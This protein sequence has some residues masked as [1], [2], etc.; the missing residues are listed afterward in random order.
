M[1]HPHFQQR[2]E[3]TIQQHSYAIK[4]LTVSCLPLKQFDQQ[5]APYP[6]CFVLLSHRNLQKISIIS[7][8]QPVCKRLKDVRFVIAYVRA[9]MH[10]YDRGQLEEQTVFFY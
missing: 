10:F 2:R 3:L 9:H 5:M 7:T 8:R 6:T 1:L 4:S